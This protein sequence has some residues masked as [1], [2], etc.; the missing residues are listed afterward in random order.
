[1]KSVNRRSIFGGAAVLGALP[2]LRGEVGVPNSAAQPIA[3]REALWI[4]PTLCGCQLQITAQWTA[5]SVL[6][7]GVAFQHPIP[8]TVE[9]VKIV[10]VCAA[11]AAH[12]T[13]PIPDDPYA[14][15]RPGYIHLSNQPKRVW[16]DAFGRKTSGPIP[17]DVHRASEA[18]RLYVHL[19]RFTGNVHRPDTCACTQYFCFESHKPNEA[20][21]LN[22]P[23]HSDRCPRHAGVSDPATLSEIIKG[24]SLGRNT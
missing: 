6:P 12:C 24:D 11:H 2:L 3:V 13:T 5:N 4:P 16:R 8:Y 10:S 14:G 22:H 1:M 19:A 23:L 21:F 9:G 17:L 15:G 7:E 20:V 18:E